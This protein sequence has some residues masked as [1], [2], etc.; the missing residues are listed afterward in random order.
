M[1]YLA[2]ISILAI[3]SCSNSGSIDQEIAKLNGTWIGE[4]GAVFRDG[5]TSDEYAINIYDFNNGNYTSN[6]TLYSDIDCINE[7]TKSN[8][9]FGIVTFVEE[10]ITVT[11]LTA[12][13]VQFERLSQSSIRPP[14]YES[15]IYIDNNI[16]YFGAFLD[17]VNVLDLSNPY[18][19]VN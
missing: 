4:C 3:A 15:L 16:L 14:S 8:E 12:S 17:D 2:L 19:K 18:M 11:G 5:S 6:F 13:K 10:V 7:T 9:E 1:K